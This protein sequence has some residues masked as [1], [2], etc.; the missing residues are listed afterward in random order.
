MYVI[1]RHKCILIDIWLV[2][3]H[4]GLLLQEL[5]KLGRLS[6]EARIPSLQ[7]NNY[8]CTLLTYSYFL[9]LFSQLK[10]QNNLKL[11]LPVNR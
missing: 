2:S 1:K 10:S 5:A 3:D 4:W 9:W 6:V 8:L 11:E 7:W